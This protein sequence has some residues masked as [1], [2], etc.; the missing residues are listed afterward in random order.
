M[1]IYTYV[2]VYDFILYDIKYGKCYFL[3][4]FLKQNG[5]TLTTCGIWNLVNYIES[6]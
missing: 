5:A 1:Y 4:E 2:D 6:L 3:V